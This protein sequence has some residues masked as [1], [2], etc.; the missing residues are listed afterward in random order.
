[1]AYSPLDYASMLG[2]RGRMDAYSAALKQAIRPDSVVLDLGTGTG[3]FA[4]LACFLGARHVYAIEPNPAIALGKKLA[5]H[6][7]VQ[8]RITWYE[9]YS[10][11]VQL[12]EKADVI[13]SDLRGLLPKRRQ[14]I[15]NQRCQEPLP[16]ARRSSSPTN[17]PSVD[18]HHIRP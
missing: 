8:D 7:G 16:Q 15:C 14:H 10:T 13:V 3:Y 1:M 11:D 5:A 4:V 17:G 2:D 18:G 6:N 12:P 9:K